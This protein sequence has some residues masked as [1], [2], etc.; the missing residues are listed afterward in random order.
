MLHRSFIDGK[1]E[2]KVNESIAYV[3]IEKIQNEDSMRNMLMNDFKIV[4]KVDQFP[5]Y[6]GIIN[7]YKVMMTFP[8]LQ[9]GFSNELTNWKKECIKYLNRLLE[10]VKYYT[11]TYWLDLLNEHDIQYF[12]IHEMTDN[13]G[14]KKKGFMLIPEGL[15]FPIKTYSI[16]E[17]NE[18]IS[19]ALKNNI[20]ISDSER[21]LFDSMNYFIKGLFNMSV[22]V[23]NSSLEVYIEEYIYDFY[24]LKYNKNESKNRTR[25]ALEGDSLHK[26]VRRNFF[27]NK[28]H[29]ELLENKMYSLFHYT[30]EKRKDAIHYNLEIDENESK[31]II[32]NVLTFSSFL[33]EKYLTI[34]KQLLGEWSY[35]N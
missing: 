21:L 29:E 34:Q 8:Y 12:R 5:D 18:E 13:N 7:V 11:K 9:E 30:R 22:I 31:T 33:I 16:Q 20:P 6:H 4:G 28:K 19:S 32:Y 14:K 15:F 23:A 24:I 2:V 25:K 10:V 3:N 35:H 26:K 27:Q 1:Y 17:R